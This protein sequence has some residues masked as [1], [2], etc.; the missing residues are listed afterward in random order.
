MEIAGIIVS[1]IATLLGTYLG[2]SLAAREN[3]SREARQLFVRMSS[4]IA[5]YRALVHDKC[6]AFILREKPRDS[7]DIEMRNVRFKIFEHTSELQWIMDSESKGIIEK[8]ETFLD[9][10]NG[11]NCG[12]HLGEDEEFN[13]HIDASIN[14]W[15]MDTAREQEQLIERLREALQLYCRDELIQT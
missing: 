12:L 14:T 1:V 10:M 4:D 5:M 13:N 2:W 7:V 8:I 15:S 9:R 11:M 6:K 3:R